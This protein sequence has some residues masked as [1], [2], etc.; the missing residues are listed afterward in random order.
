MATITETTGEEIPYSF[1]IETSADFF[2]RNYTEVEL[3]ELLAIR[4][5]AVYQKEIRLLVPSMKDA[6]QRV[7]E[8]LLARRPEIVAKL[9]ARLAG[10]AK[11]PPE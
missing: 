2:R 8:R 7:Q 1:I 3:K 6:G 5:S 10:L 11:Q 9:K 4:Q